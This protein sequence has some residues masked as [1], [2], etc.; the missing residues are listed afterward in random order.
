M[1]RRCTNHYLTF[2]VNEGRNPYQK[3]TAQQAKDAADAAIGRVSIIYVFDDGYAYVLDADTARSLLTRSDDG[4][5]AVD[6]LTGR[7]VPNDAMMKSFLGV[8][9][10]LCRAH[11]A[12][13]SSEGLF[14]STRG[15]TYPDRPDR[16]YDRDQS[17]RRAQLS[18]H[19]PDRRAE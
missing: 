7:Y 9:D 19:G 14:L 1:R 17:R 6:T 2:G 3:M 16:E 11:T 10:E 4:T 13:A 18:S 8:I 12:T 15:D 5:L